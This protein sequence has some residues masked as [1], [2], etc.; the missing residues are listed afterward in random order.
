MVSSLRSE[1][2]AVLAFCDVDVIGD[3]E[4]THGTLAVVEATPGDHLWKG[5][6]LARRL[7]GGASLQMCGVVVRR[8]PA[9][10]LGGLDP[11]HP[12]VTD[13]HL[14]LRLLEEGAAVH[15]AETLAYFGD[16]PGKL[17][18]RLERSGEAQRDVRRLLEWARERSWARGDIRGAT[19]RTSARFAKVALRRISERRWAAGWHY[20][21]ESLR[22]GILAGKSPR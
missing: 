17:T 20:A 9:I 21:V 12:F 15:V 13:W 6:D 8:E 22:L 3:D 1:E 4:L 18:W 5:Q 7:L 16:H 10:A 14:W 2:S 11:S 19:A